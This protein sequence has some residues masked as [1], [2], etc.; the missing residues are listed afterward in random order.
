MAV[1]RDERPRAVPRERGGAQ[2]SH[3]AGDLERKAVLVERAMRSIR[4]LARRARPVAGTE[5]D[6]LP[7]AAIVDRFAAGT[8]VLAEAIGAGKDPVTAREIL[9]VTAAAADPRTVGAGDWQVQSLVM[10]LRSPIVDAL[11]AAGMSPQEA[12]ETLTEL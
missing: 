7:V 6:L 11:E 12:R 9:A 4:V 8:R 1:D 2:A 5:R 3:R 10:L